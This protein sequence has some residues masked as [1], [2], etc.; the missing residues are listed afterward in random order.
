[1]VLSFCTHKTN[2]H[3]RTVVYFYVIIYKCVIFSHVSDSEYENISLFDLWPLQ[4]YADGSQYG[5]MP[6]RDLGSHDSISPPYV[7]SRLAGES[8]E[9][10]LSMMGCRL[11]G[12]TFVNEKRIFWWMIQCWSRTNGVWFVIHAG[13]C[14]LEDNQSSLVFIFGSLFCSLWFYCGETCTHLPT[15]L[16]FGLGLIQWVRESPRMILFCCFCS[17]TSIFMSIFVVS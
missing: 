8:G 3:S 11:S 9:I 17:E 7:N 2:Y 6:S 15:M 14:F 4:N 12:L 16:C 10:T 5:H 1:M 13:L